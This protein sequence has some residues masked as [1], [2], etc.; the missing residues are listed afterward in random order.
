MRRFSLAYLTAP[1]SPPEAL[2]LAARAGYDFV[3]LRVAPSAPGGPHA[4]L[5][6]DADLLR[7]TLEAR[8]ETGVGVFDV[9]IIRLDAGFRAEDAQAFLDICAALGARAV[10]VAGDDPDEAR[11]TD[12]FAALCALAAPRGLTANL[13]FMPWTAAKDARAATRIV[14]QAG[15]ENGRVLIDALHFARSSTVLDDISAIAPHVLDYAQICDAPAEA[16]AT[17]EG[18][19]HA[20]RVERLPPGE[21]AIDLAGLI[22]RLPGELPL[23]VEVP[24]RRGIAGWGQEEWA[25]RTLA[26]SR[27]IAAN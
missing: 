12:S 8:D 6:S 27:L 1:V 3:G 7:R 25:R 26:A 11:L 18:L 19:I 5:L 23:S 10:L 14:E 2:R 20:A 4:P 21:G 17:V 13:E 16:P 15:A 22:A 9:E 24:S